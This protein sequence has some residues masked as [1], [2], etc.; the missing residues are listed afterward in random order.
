[1]K[2]LYW[3]Q[4][5]RSTLLKNKNPDRMSN[6]QNKGNEDKNQCSLDGSP[7]HTIPQLRK[8]II[9][10]TE[11]I[12]HTEELTEVHIPVSGDKEGRH[13]SKI[14]IYGWHSVHV[15]YMGRKLTPNKT[16]SLGK[17]TRTLG[18]KTG[19]NASD[20]TNLKDF[21]RIGNWNLFFETT[22]K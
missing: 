11:H 6:T 1:M 4:R 3:K 19:Q 8:I 16:H 14:I 13:I 21:R 22:K 9:E 7:I 15:N 17:S 18:R 5:K 20:I 2:N 10:N 12:H